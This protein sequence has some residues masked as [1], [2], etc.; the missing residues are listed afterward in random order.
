MRCFRSSWEPGPPTKFPPLAGLP[1]RRSLRSSSPAVTSMDEP[2][3]KLE[4]QLGLQPTNI[5][6]VDNVGDRRG[7]YLGL[8]WRSP[9]RAADVSLRVCSIG[10]E[11]LLPRC[12]GGVAVDCRRPR[13]YG[14]SR[15][16]Q[17]TSAPALNGASASCIE[18]PPTKLVT[19]REAGGLCGRWWLRRS[20]GL[21][22]TCTASRANRACGD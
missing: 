9:V 13:S 22:C 16:V 8:A 5:W 12:F 19:C 1:G 2:P 6:A 3:A 18:A 4:L 10:A 21:P 14:D 20:M 7:L 17:S 11:G 15:G